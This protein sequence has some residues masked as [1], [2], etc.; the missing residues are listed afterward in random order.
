M[1]QNFQT[2]FIPKKVIVEEVVV[3]GKKPVNIFTVFGIIIFLTMAIVFGG[4]YFY[5]NLLNTRISKDK[6]SLQKAAQRFEVSRINELEIL[7]KRLSA[8]NKIIDS[9]I[10][11]SPI[12]EV[13]QSITMKSIRYTKFTYEFSEKQEIIVKMSGQAESYRSIALQ[14]DLF[15]ANKNLIEPVFSNLTLDDK[16]SVLFDLE[17]KIDPILVNYK[18]KLDQERVIT[19]VADPIINPPTLIN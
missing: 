17:F 5:E 18:Q 10:S 1:E 19:P 4:L 3:K 14:S 15:S 8:A 13:L 16:G 11:I 7:N 2:S 9:H 12:F 6:D